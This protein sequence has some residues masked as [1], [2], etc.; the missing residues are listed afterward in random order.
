MIKDIEKILI[1]KER[2]AERVS[3]I[4]EQI[5]TDYAGEEIIMVCIL[6]GSCFFF[7]DLA[8]QIKESAYLEFMS[9]S[10]Y[11]GTRSSG[12]VRINKDISMPVEGKHL[13]IVEDIIDTGYT[14]SY[15]KR[16]L[17]ERRPKSLKICALLDKPSRRETG[18]VGDYIGFTVPDE[19]VVGYG[20]DYDQRYRNL[21]EIG[22]LKHEIY[23]R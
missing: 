8:R 14:L 13:L 16:I 10:S 11:N 23:A 4:A 18:L 22:V 9:V 3:E 6:R 17:S 12:E 21:P 7:T 2:I 19:F 5:N 1:S 20:L 15:L